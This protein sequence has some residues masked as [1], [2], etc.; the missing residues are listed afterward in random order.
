[1]EETETL[2]E[3]DLFTNVAFLKI[4]EE[5]TCFFTKPA[6]LPVCLIWGM[7]L[8]FWTHPLSPTTLDLF[9]LFH[10]HCHSQHSVSTVYFLCKRLLLFS[11][12]EVLSLQS[13]FHTIVKCQPDHISMPEKFPFHNKS[14]FFNKDI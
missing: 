11:P 9:F 14:Q 6:F 5:N 12:P 4:L 2:Q 7:A 10:H 3:F 1:M 13:I 8:S